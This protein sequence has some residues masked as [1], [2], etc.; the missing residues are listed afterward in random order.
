MLR[1][2]ASWMATRATR[3]DGID[4]AEADRLVAGERPDPQW[5]GLGPLLDAARA[6]ATGEELAGERQA[7]DQLVVARRAALTASP[8][9]R[10]D[11]RVRPTVRMA[12]VSLATG[13]ALLVLAG[14]AAGTGSLPA[15]LQQRAHEMFG[16]LGVPPPDAG[17]GRGGGPSGGTTPSAPATVPPP[18]RPAG[19]DHPSGSS[20]SPGSGSPNARAL[21]RAWASTG[22]DPDGSGMSSPAWRALVTAAGGRSRV[23]AMCTSLIGAPPAA[24][25]APTTTSRSGGGPAVP[26]RSG[27]PQ[28][29]RPTP[30]PAH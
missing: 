10:R 29:G 21:C 28:R 17:D 16:M 26:G 5:Y 27:G 24:T 30:G 2:I 23:P 19:T 22:R 4:L 7:V 6:P 11:A 18:S 9:R 12:V 15:G 3:H 20:T 25:A 13:L 14:V 8:V 1:W